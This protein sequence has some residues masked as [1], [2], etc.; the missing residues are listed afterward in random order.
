MLEVSELVT[1]SACAVFGII[2]SAEPIAAN[3]VAIEQIYTTCAGFSFF[4]LFGMLYFFIGL[5][6]FN[7][8]TSVILK[9]LLV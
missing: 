3:I 7:V 5:L 6:I 4:D 8:F 1:G 2:S 9:R